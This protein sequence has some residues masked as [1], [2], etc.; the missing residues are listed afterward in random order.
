MKVPYYRQSTDYNCAPAT[1]KMALEY[2]GINKS[3]KELAKELKTTPE[4]GTDYRNIINFVKKSGLFFYEKSNSTLEEL[5]N[6]IRN[7]YPV[8]V[9]FV[10]PIHEEDHFALVVGI[11][12]CEVILNDPW[13]GEGFKILKGD[14]EERWHD[15]ENKPR[16]W[17]MV[18]A[19][20]KIRLA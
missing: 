7:N 12:D 8:I 20:E 10:E 11:E 18:I 19:K 9:S 15:A 17:M 6:L 14:F 3:E 4:E 2:V 1:L 16:R 5:E 13:N